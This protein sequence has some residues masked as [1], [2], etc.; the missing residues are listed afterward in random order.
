[1]YVWPA[2]FETYT[3]IKKSLTILLLL[4]CFCS[5]ISFG[6]TWKLNS[7]SGSGLKTSSSIFKDEAGN[8]YVAGSFSDTLKIEN[9]TLTTKGN[10]DGYIASYS[11]SGSLKWVKSFGGNSAEYLYD[12]VYKKGII[13]F[14]G[15][16]LSESI[17]FLADTITNPDGPGG[18]SDSYIAAIDTLGNFVWAKSLGSSGARNDQIADIEVTDNAIYVAGSFEGIFNAGNNVIAASSGSTDAY[19]VRMDL[20]GNAKWGRFAHGSK[21]E[22]GSAIKT[23]SFGNVYVAGS[24]GNS[25]GLGSFSV[26]IGSAQLFANGNYGF[27]DVF[28]AKFDTS[29]VFKSA[30]RDGGGNPDYARKLLVDGT[31]ILLAGNYYYNTNLGGDIYNTDGG[32][33][34][35]IAAYDTS[36]SHQWSQSFTSTQGTSPT[37]DNVLGIEKDN[38]GQYFL[39]MQHSPVKHSLYYISNNG[40]LLN[41]DDLLTQSNSSYSG[42]MFVDR[43]CGSVYVSASFINKVKCSTDSLIGNYG[44]V[45]WAVRTDSSKFLQ[46]PSN[47]AK[48]TS[49]SICASAP[50]FSVKVNSVSGAE[51]YSWQLIP[52]RAGSI[53]GN[54]TSA[55]VNVDSTYFGNLKIICRAT[56]GCSVSDPSDTARIFIKQVPATPFIGLNGILIITNAIAQTYNWYNGNALAGSTSVNYFGASSGGYYVLR[57]ENDGCISEASNGVFVMITD[58]GKDKV[59][60]EIRIVLDDFGNLKLINSENKQINRVEIIDL[61]GKRV[62]EASNAESLNNR[63]LQVLS[64]SVYILRLK[65]V[66]DRIYGFRFVKR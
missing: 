6:Q 41:R 13:Y 33:E 36:L 9:Q 43:N 57:T 48:N 8:V 37:D 56:S 27:N 62:Y 30:V 65:D 17:N 50:S 38:S 46:P 64:P 60:N 3:M 66:D 14:G 51:N 53:S 22:Y 52:K 15:E 63:I 49:D 47:I 18:Y 16:F 25:S 28:L 4:A 42:G 20:N 10:Y 35:F 21:S 24:F 11:S 39:F 29:G 58:V 54:D 34:G 61:F 12:A 40:T 2:T 7:I 59:E 32:Y 26:Y 45:F 23:D 31:K 1:M 44:D 5:Q 55:I 19:F